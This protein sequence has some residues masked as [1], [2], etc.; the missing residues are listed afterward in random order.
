MENCNPGL[1]E[2]R[3]TAKETFRK[4]RQSGAAPV[5]R[6][7][8]CQRLL[9]QGVWPN[10]RALADGL[11]ESLVQI[12]RY[13]KAS[14]VLEEIA[15]VFGDR[16]LSY[17]TVIILDEIAEQ[18]GQA[19]LIE[20]AKRLGVRNDLNIRSILSALSTNDFAADQGDKIRLVAMKKENYVRLYS[21]EI[22]K[23]R[24]TLPQL[25]RQIVLAMALLSFSP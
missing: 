12:S 14:R 21:P 24:R 15:R 1:E 8:F 17:R 5:E 2:L 4:M 13:F 6:G 19:K 25:E 22:S 7:R 23:I 11:G 18:I 3:A 10:R 16:R 20:N 9:T